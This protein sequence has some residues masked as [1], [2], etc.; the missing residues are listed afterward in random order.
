MSEYGLVGASIKRRSNI[1]LYI[2]LA[3]VAITCLF[4]VADCESDR[5]AYR[6]GVTLGGK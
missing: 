6:P 1:V 4:G 3:V 5:L 2:L